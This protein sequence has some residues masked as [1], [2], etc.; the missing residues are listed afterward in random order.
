MKFP[1]RRSVFE[2]KM[3]EEMCRPNLSPVVEERTFRDEETG[4][5]IDVTTYQDNTIHD[6]KERFEITKVK[7]S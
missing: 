4:A 1:H 3:I 5:E 6:V 2:R 7:K